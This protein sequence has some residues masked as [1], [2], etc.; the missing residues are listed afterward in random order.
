MRNLG[1][2]GIFKQAQQLQEDISKVK[3]ELAGM[4]VQATSGGG[5]IEVTANG[6]QQILDIKIDPEV[7][8][9]NDKEMLEDLIVAGVNLA[10]E[11]AQA[12]AKDELKKV[13]GDLLSQL[14]EGFKIPDLNL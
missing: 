7:I 1:I 11:R 4:K 6:K 2:L 8:K 5:M 9:L 10:L 3:Q 13:T 12:L 14:P